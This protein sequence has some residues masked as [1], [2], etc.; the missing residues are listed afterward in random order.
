VILSLPAVRNVPA[1]PL[2]ALIAPQGDSAAKTISFKHVLD[3][4]ETA[5]D[6]NVADSGGQKAD[7]E[8]TN[9][10]KSLPEQA[11]EPRVATQHNKL[12]I[13][14]ATPQLAQL[15]A[16]LAR[17]TLSPALPHNQETAGSEEKSPEPGE[18]FQPATETAANT[19]R[20]DTLRPVPVPVSTKTT[21]Q[22]QKLANLPAAKT[23]TVGA[24]A[25]LTKSA[26]LAPHDARI[27]QP[28][29][30]ISNPQPQ[31]Q[32]QPTADAQKPQSTKTPAPESVPQISKAPIESEAIAR[33]EPSGKDQTRNGI[34]SVSTKPEQTEE[35]SRS[36]K[37]PAP[38]KASPHPAAQQHTRAVPAAHSWTN[39]K[40]AAQPNQ[41]LPQH[42]QI[43]ET[44]KVAQPVTPASLPATPVP[45]E[46][47]TPS[48]VTPASAKATP[49]LRRAAQV[50][51]SP[52]E[53]RDAGPAKADAGQKKTQDP[54]PTHVTASNGDQSQP[55]KEVSAVPV[56][57]S[58]VTPTP[59]TSVPVTGTL[60]P[61]IATRN[62]HAE[63][64]FAPVAAPK[65]PLAPSAANFAFEIRMLA[66]EPQSSY[67]S[68]TQ[69]KPAVTIAEPIA[70]PPATS[71]E[72]A[73]TQPKPAVT[74]HTQQPQQSETQV[75]TSSKRDV[76]TPEAVQGKTDTRNSADT[77]D[78]KDASAPRT[79]ETA[80]NVSRWSELTAPQPQGATA[81]P[82]S[83]E[84]TEPA[85]ASQATAAQ[86]THVMAPELPKAP[87]STEILLHLT[88]NDQSSAAI[89]VSDR[90]GAVNLSVHASDPVL[91]ESLRSNLGDL[92]AQLNQ[93]GWKAEAVKPAALAAPPDGQQDSHANGQGSS[94]HQHSFSDQRQAPRERRN[95]NGNWQQ[96]FEQQTSSGDAHPG[97]KG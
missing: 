94:Q 43:I 44:A 19:P 78:A 62:E 17:P 60:E 28:V 77:H 66:P 24:R 37:A 39:A 35:T 49:V 3:A 47:E 11:G 57:V 58:V 88:S 74:P 26:P 84:L 91:R 15:A 67:S 51:S 64:A 6:E 81:A 86:E 8:S 93:Q 42:Q 31:P 23:T 52:A 54:A 13:P 72:P 30:S 38:L 9:V 96:E 18:V 41:V 55:V 36:T 2:A 14:L 80:T 32:V 85:H 29:R 76:Q 68:H 48:T 25:G 70:E 69:A 27:E 5:G 97:G 1:I 65:T 10:R 4:F 73:V 61:S 56:P 12:T 46:P 79:A 83:S 45:A 16:H 89:R 7:S 63:A 22:V 59:A 53:M 40:P 75:S 71:A 34:L 20:A 33:K 92:S 21:V 87:A 82:P 95:P 90:A 50:T